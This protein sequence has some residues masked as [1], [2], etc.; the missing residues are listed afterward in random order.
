M[1]QIAGPD[2]RVDK[3]DDTSDERPSDVEQCAGVPCLPVPRQWK[4]AQHNRN[5]A[6]YGKDRIAHDG[7]GIVGNEV[8]VVR[9]Q[10]SWFCLG[11][12]LLI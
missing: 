12:R 3:V 8:T 7:E 5:A 11:V 10:Y 4:Q 6:E 2:Q 9:F 1:I